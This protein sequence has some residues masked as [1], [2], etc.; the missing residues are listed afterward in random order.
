MLV[1][2]LA[3][4]YCVG[5]PA[6]TRIPAVVVVMLLISFLLLIVAGV[7]TTVSVTAVADTVLL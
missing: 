5:I 6:V 2:L 7:T 1:L 4:L 3:S